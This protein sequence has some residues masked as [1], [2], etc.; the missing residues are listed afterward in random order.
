MHKQVRRSDS[1]LHAGNTHAGRNRSLLKRAS[2]CT[3]MQSYSAGC[4][5]AWVWRA[6]CRRGTCEGMHKGLT[7]VKPAGSF[8]GCKC[9]QINGSTATD[10]R[11]QRRLNGCGCCAPLMGHAGGHCSCPLQWDWANPGCNASGWTS[12]P[13]QTGLTAASCT[14]SRLELSRT[15]LP[16][17][18]A[19]MPT[20]VFST[21]GCGFAVVQWEPGGVVCSTYSA[22]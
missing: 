3:D 1:S 20:H 10:A 5:D 12:A 17:D 15:L 14:D 18:A 13:D 2:H 4:R 8:G 22:F 19:C 21:A 11:W 16:S 9:L 6:V 7:A